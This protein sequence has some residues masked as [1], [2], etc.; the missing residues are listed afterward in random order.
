M[1]ETPHLY[2]ERPYETYTVTHAQDDT[3]WV[4]FEDT[5]PDDHCGV[6]QC[7]ACGYEYD[8]PYRVEK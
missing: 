2:I 6:L 7:G 1:R 8:V 3:I 5:S 4:I